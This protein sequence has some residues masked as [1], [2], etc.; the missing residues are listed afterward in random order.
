MFASRLSTALAF[1][2]LVTA[3]GSAY[4]IMKIGLN[5]SPPILFAGIRTFLGGLAMTAMAVGW[6]G[7]VDLRHTWSALLISTAFNVVFF[8]TLQTLAVFYLPSG[9]A[10]VLIYLQPILVGFLAW[11]FLSESLTI[12]KIAGLLLGFLGVLAVS[13]ESI[14][15]RVSFVGVVVGMFAAL[16]WAIGTV[17]FKRVQDR[18]STLWFVAI[19]FMVGS[20]V[21]LLAGSLAEAWSAITWSAPLWASLL[22][23]SLFSVGLAWILWMG[24]VEAGEASRV[25][26]YVFVVPLISLLI[27]TFFLHE[28]FTPLLLLG[29]GL[30]VFGIYLVNRWSV[31]S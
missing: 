13:A 26:A 5:Y 29:G 24:L 10:A 17:Y 9:L 14:S 6:G 31:S 16:S 28:S 25:S 11:M 15:G 7:H 21:L 8:V 30:I 1:I 27:G 19:P 12:A 23:T 22:Y 20:S 2:T 18:V 3:W 4:P